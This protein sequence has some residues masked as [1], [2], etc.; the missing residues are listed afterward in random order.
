MCIRDSF[1][2]NIRWKRLREQ[3]NRMPFDYHVAGFGVNEKDDGSGGREKRYA[4]VKLKSCAALKEDQ[5]ISCFFYNLARTVNDK[6]KRSG[7]RGDSGGPIVGFVFEGMLSGSSDRGSDTCRGGRYIN[8]RHSAMFEG[9]SD[10]DW[11]PDDYR[12]PEG[13]RATVVGWF[14]SIV[15]N[16]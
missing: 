2:S 15:E 10:E 8:Y 12:I 11:G 6:D 3:L 1:I 7:C 9:P 5:G 14:K 4:I 13:D 16:E